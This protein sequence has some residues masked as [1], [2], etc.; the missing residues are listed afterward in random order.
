MTNISAVLSIGA[1]LCWTALG[2]LNLTNKEFK[3]SKS[4]YWWA[5]SLALLG[6]I[7]SLVSI[8]QR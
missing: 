7:E 5:Y 3:P 2:I 4:D 8:W 1:V 6:L